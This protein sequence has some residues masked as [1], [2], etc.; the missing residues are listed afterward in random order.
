MVGLSRMG[1]T[2]EEACLK[3]LEAEK[4][5][6]HKAFGYCLD[7]SFCSDCDG[8]YQNVLEDLC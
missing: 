6:T 3:A 7:F 8:N 4:I 5:Q 1:E 2:E